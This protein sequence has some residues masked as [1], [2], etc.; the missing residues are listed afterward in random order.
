M[1]RL[2]VYRKLN[3]QFLVLAIFLTAITSIIFGSINSLAE[4][5]KDSQNQQSSLVLSKPP[6]EN[7][8]SKLAK[9]LQTR[10]ITVDENEFRHIQNVFENKGSS[11]D[12]KIVEKRGGLFVIEAD[13]EQILDLSRNMHEEFNKCAGFMAHQ[14]FHAARLSIDEALRADSSQQ[15]VE[16]TINNQA[17]VNTMIAATL[18]SQILETIT[19]LSTDFPNRRYNQPS[20]LNSAN[21]IKNKW[22]ELAA[23]RSDITI[24]FFDHAAV[25]SPQ[26][27]IILTVQG[28]TFPN[29]VVVLGAHQDSI[30]RSGGGET[31]NAPGADD[32]ASGIAN[33]TEAIRVI[34]EKKFRPKRTVKFMAYAAE[35]IG[36]VGSNAIAADFQ[37]RGV[38]VIGVLQLDMTNYKSPNSTLDIA[39][40]TDLT[41]APQN[42][43]LRNLIKTYQPSL[44]IVDSSCGYCSDHASWNNKGFAASYTYEGPYSNPTIHTPNDTLAQSGN[45]A[46]H[47]VKFTNIALSYI[48]ELAKGTLNITTAASATVS[49]KVLSGRRGIPQAR[50]SLTD[51]GGAVRTTITNPF[52]YYQF[53]DVPVGAMYI[54]EAQSKR[55]TFT[56]KVVNITEDL[57]DLN[58]YLF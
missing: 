35:E 41:N 40:I 42:E 7:T 37:S 31:G 47:A 57:T 55:Y 33:L 46:S 30:N 56:Q 12:L 28:T 21:W 45:N 38:N 49:G 43:F 16:Y 19:R 17:T 48:G 22:T 13:E 2:S 39:I 27:S 1:T 8:D 53:T 44:G 50:V 36:L 3:L 52:G 18:E 54:I 15:L 11:F 4:S 26:P 34:V 6:G 58:F 23:G 14:T 29:E 51:A 10:W 5:S 20:G 32:D 9:S 24:E 25:A